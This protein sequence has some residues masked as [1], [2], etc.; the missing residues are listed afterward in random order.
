[1]AKGFQNQGR[2]EVVFTLVSSLSTGNGVF[3]AGKSN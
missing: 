2:K 1:L 3:G